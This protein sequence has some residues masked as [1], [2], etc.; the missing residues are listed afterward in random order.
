MMDT[1]QA[2]LKFQWYWITLAAIF[3]ACLL[4]LTRELAGCTIVA[5]CIGFMNPE[6]VL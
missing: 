3:G 6:E 2:P 1:H 5:I 4:L